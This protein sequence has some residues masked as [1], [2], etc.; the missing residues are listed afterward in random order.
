MAKPKIVP[1]GRPPSPP[2]PAGGAQK[3]PQLVWHLH[4]D[5]RLSGQVF[6]PAMV[7]GPGSEEGTLNLMVFR[8][9]TLDDATGLEEVLNVPYV[10]R[11]HIEDWGPGRR[12]CCSDL[13]PPLAAEEPA[14]R[15]TPPPRP[16]QPA[17][18]RGA[19]Q[20][21]QEPADEGDAIDAFLTGGSTRRR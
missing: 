9:E 1:L 5:D 4:A 18:G 11:A 6:R 2:P 13:L 3:M 17:R 21:A 20:G 8:S 7:F 15:P 14:E 16:T 12:F 19:P 10:P